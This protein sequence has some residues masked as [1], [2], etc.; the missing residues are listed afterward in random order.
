MA[1]RYIV[2]NVSGQT[3]TGDLTI[4]GNLVVSG[5]S[6]DWQ[7]ITINIS[8]SQILNLKSQPIELLPPPGDNKYYIWE[9]NIEYTYGTIG[10]KLVSGYLL[11]SNS[12]PNNK[13]GSNIDGNLIRESVNQIAS[14]SSYTDKDDSNVGV[15]LN[16]G[17]SISSTIENP[18]N[19]DG[20]LKIKLNYKV[21]TF[22]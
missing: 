4:S 16:V 11:I 6:N 10:Y 14:F 17:V 20:T 12:T 9:G 5:T 21:I 3:I 22:G 19:G 13:R 2:N 15:P 7:S 1:T 18:T 8:S